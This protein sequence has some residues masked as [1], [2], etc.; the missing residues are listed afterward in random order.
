M[1]SSIRW[2]S[3]LTVPYS[4]AAILLW[5]SPVQEKPHMIVT[6]PECQ[7]SAAPHPGSSSA[8][9]RL[10]P[11]VVSRHCDADG[12]RSRQSIPAIL[13]RTPRKRA[14]LTIS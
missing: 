2:R 9:E 14:R 6:C 7:T 4:I 3:G 13:P 10:R 12:M 11:S 8:A 1:S 5:G